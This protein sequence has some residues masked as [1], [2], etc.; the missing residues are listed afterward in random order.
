MGFLGLEDAFEGIPILGEMFGDSSGEKAAASQQRSF[1][2]M[3]DAYRQ[4]RPEAAQA[5]QQQMQNMASMWGPL[6]DMVM[7]NTGRGI[8]FDAVMTPVVSPEMLAVGAAPPQP[9]YSTAAPQPGAPPVAGAWNPA[10]SNQYPAVP[11]QPAPA[12]PQQPAVL[13]NGPTGP[14]VIPGYGG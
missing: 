5:R 10:L 4:Y 6:N 13:P 11:L 7:A 3:Q 9:Q 8:D 14:G 2:E 1:K 12:Q